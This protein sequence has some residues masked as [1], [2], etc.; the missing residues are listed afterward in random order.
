MGVG[1]G[2]VPSRGRKRRIERLAAL[3]LTLAGREMLGG[4]GRVLVPELEV[5]GYTYDEIVEA[6]NAL[7]S[8]GAEVSVMGN[9]IK[10]KVVRK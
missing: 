10:I 3:I 5:E 9:V 6:L 4:V 2:E 7:R 8:E 1:D